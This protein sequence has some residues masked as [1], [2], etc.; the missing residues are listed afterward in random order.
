VLAVVFKLVTKL[1]VAAVASA[2]PESFFA[3]SLK[4][5]IPSARLSISSGPI[6][7]SSSILS[8]FCVTLSL[9]CISPPTPIASVDLRV[10]I[11]LSISSS[12]GSF[13]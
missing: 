4:F 5:F 3:F 11:F 7:A 1:S 6:L 2:N 12:I 8:N 10:S 13:G 9:I